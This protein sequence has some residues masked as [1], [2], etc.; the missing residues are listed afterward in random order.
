MMLELLTI[1]LSVPAAILCGV[2]L[3]KWIPEA[4]RALRRDKDAAD[5]LVLGVTIGF[6]G[7]ELNLLYWT[8]YWAVSYVSAT[9]SP[10]LPTFLEWGSTWNLFT[11]QIPVIIASWCHL[12]AYY[13]FGKG[14]GQHPSKPLFHSLYIALAL[15]GAAWAL[16]AGL[17]PDLF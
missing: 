14:K 17:I 3:T 4:Y 11:R 9:Q 6:L 2:V 15:A 1:G 13:L 7:I 16:H 10:I 8:A 12:H 5:W